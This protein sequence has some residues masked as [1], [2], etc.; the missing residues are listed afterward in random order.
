M[1]GRKRALDNIY[2]ERFWRSLK[3]EDIYLK[4]YRNL[5]ELKAGLSRYFE[6]FNGERFHAACGY[7]TPNEM[8]ESCFKNGER[9]SVALVA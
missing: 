3:Y 8:Y 2:V 9:E 4:D 6:F 1:D 5:V 7:Q